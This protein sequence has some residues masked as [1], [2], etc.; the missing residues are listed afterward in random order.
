MAKENESLIF[1]MGAKFG[2]DGAV[3]F[4]TLKA[5]A[6]KQKD[7]LA[8]TN[9]QM[10]A[11]LV[12][13][14]Q[15]DLNPF[16]KEI[17]AFPDKRGGIVPVVGVDGWSRI[18][19]E[20]PALD[21][22]EFE[23]SEKCHVMNGSNIQCHEW[24]ECLIYR[25]DRSRPIRVREYLDECYRFVDG[26][27]QTHPKRMLR[28]KTIIQCARIAFGFSGIYDQDEAE[29]IDEIVSGSAVVVHPNK[30]EPTPSQKSTALLTKQELIPLLEQ[31]A[32]RAQKASAWSA[33]HEYAQARFVGE[34]LQYAT[35]FLKKKEAEH[36]A[37]NDQATG[38]ANQH[39]KPAPENAL[40]HVGN[41][42]QGHFFP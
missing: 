35:D 27:W 19:N 8:P 37:E 31:L 36:S 5:T 15:Y 24:I 18:V 33:A 12:V 28:H 10:L 32:T 13:A 4:D 25:K 34:H 40:S 21:G 42:D 41:D 9:E 7:G 39:E 2:V 30:A 17:Y 26:P 38:V 3:F 22:I 23:Y 6:F 16:T 29:R 11:L 1:R 20:H 14:N